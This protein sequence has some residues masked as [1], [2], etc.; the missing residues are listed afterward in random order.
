MTPERIVE[1][2]RFVRLFP[3]VGKYIDECLDEI[4]RLNHEIE[5][6]ESKRFAI[7]PSRTY[8]A[9]QGRETDADHH[10]D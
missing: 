8:F 9:T 7:A 4:E 6:L 10:G 2:R 3:Y 5:K 1:L